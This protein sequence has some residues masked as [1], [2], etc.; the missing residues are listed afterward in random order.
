MDCLVSDFRQFAN[1]I[2]GV[3]L[4][5]TKFPGTLPVSVSRSSIPSLYG[6]TQATFAEYTLSY[7]ADGFDGGR[8]FLLYLRVRTQAYAVLLDRT[9]QP[10]Q[11]AATAYTEA[12][13]GTLFD[14][15][16]M[17][18][19]DSSV[20]I[21]IFDTM[22][23]NGT[24]V[25]KQ[26]YLFRLELARLFLHEVA[27]VDVTA[28]SRVYPPG[29]EMY[30]S[31]FPDLQI[32]AGSWLGNQLRFQVKQVYYSRALA[33]LPTSTHYPTDGFVWTLVTA[34]YTPFRTNPDCVLKWKPYD[35]IT[36]DFYIRS[37]ALD[38]VDFYPSQNPDQFRGQ[39]GPWGLF[40]DHDG[41]M[42]LVATTS[43]SV[44]S[45]GVYECYWRF[46]GW[47]VK[48]ARTDKDVPN[49]ISTV[50]KT[51]QSLTEKVTLA[52]LCN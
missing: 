27:R 3:G 43:S 2:C 22:A 15:E 41:A 13:Q 11:L 5:N 51:I 19:P 24:S 32:S 6:L 35:E 17:K 49:H 28:T 9:Y 26:H 44:Q 7:K 52:D 4:A 47:V 38:S 23:V 30:P 20:L 18:L 25:T 42:V 40:A 37:V 34:P 45:A 48:Q 1:D 8:Y 14:V 46:P 36:V 21:L 39:S 31:N 12:F 50:E 16:V 10:V 33:N 29:P